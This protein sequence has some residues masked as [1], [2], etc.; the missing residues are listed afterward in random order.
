MALGFIYVLSNPDMPGLVKIGQSKADPD[1][2]AAELCGFREVP[3]SNYGKS[4]TRIS[5]SPGQ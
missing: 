5:V 3:D 2:R 1:L 4:R